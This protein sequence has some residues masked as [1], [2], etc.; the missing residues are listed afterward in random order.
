MKTRSYQN[1]TMNFKKE[2]EPNNALVHLS[3]N[4]NTNLN[5][6]NKSLRF[7][8]DLIKAFSSISHKTLIHFVK[9]IEIDK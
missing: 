2:L 8:L 4:I 1:P 5:K 9:F 3:M 7:F 6:I